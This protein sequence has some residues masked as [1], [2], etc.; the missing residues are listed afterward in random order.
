MNRWSRLGFGVVVGWMAYAGVAVAQAP[1]C[2]EQGKPA[3]VTLQNPSF[4]A[5]PDG[6]P[7]HW[8]AKEH[9]VSGHYEFTVD[10]QDAHS[11]PGSARIR[12]VKVEDFGVLDQT[13]TV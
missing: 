4:N 11:T 8:V 10:A 12:Q 2:P 3:K 6:R 7:Q 9:R 13:L 1:A 5:G